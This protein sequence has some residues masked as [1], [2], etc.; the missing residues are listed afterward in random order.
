MLAVAA[1]LRE[2]SAGFVLGF[3]VRDVAK[4]A[5]GQYLMRKLDRECRAAQERMVGCKHENTVLVDTGMGP[6][7]KKCVD[8]WALHFPG[9]SVGPEW[10][11]NVCPP[12]PGAKG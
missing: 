3:L 4:I 8:C 9:A 2:V 1:M 5:W 6:I 7:T 11:P 10:N 12:P